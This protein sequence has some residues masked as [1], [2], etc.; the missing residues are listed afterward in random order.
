M[1]LLSLSAL[2]LGWAGEAKLSKYDFLSGGKPLFS[3][4]CMDTECFG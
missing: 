2:D 4:L 1:G 3:G